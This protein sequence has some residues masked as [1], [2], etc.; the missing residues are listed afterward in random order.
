MIKPKEIY[1]KHNQFTKVIKS[2]TITSRT[3]FLNSSFKTRWSAF[4]IQPI[5]YTDITTPFK[6]STNILNK[7]LL[8]LVLF[9][10]V[11]SVSLSQSYKGI[12]WRLKHQYMALRNTVHYIHTSFSHAW[13]C[14]IRYT[15]SI[16]HFHMHGFAQYGTL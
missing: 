11:Q 2:K 4:S 10:P 3:T 15:I 13:L 1:I 6:Y 5:T 9:V 14:A 16:L 8:S 12:I 7:V